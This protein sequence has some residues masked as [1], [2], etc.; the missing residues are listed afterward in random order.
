MESEEYKL[1][2]LSLTLSRFLQMQ[3]FRCHAFE[4]FNG[5]QQQQQLQQKQ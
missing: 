3:L 2:S 5:W 4:H 1:S